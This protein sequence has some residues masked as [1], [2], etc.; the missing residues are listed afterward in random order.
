[1]W[2]FGA[3][4]LFV[5]CF[6][7]WIGDLFNS[8]TKGIISGL[9]AASVLYIIGYLSGVIP[10]DQPAAL[11]LGAMIGSYGQMIIVVN[12]GTMVSLND[13]LKQWKTVL[14]CLVSLAVMVFAVGALG[15]M[16]FGRE[17]G[18]LAVAPISG[19]AVASAMV[20]E[21]ATNAGRADL[22]ALAMLFNVL[23]L[24]F[25]VPASSFLLKKYCT[26]MAARG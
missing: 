14:T 17:I 22:A 19:G 26:K 13:L 7:F 21:T 9:L 23:Q 5:L 25:G 12:L 4:G 16:L 11:G 3:F 1:M 20:A 10:T 2:Q 24:L 18:L 8:R 6:A 15:T